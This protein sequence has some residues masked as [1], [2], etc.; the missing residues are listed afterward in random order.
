MVSQIFSNLNSPHFQQ[1]QSVLRAYMATFSFL[2]I[3]Q[4][5]EVIKTEKISIFGFLRFSV[6]ETCFPSLTGD[7]FVTLQSCGFD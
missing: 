7:L 4:L 3:R 5:T 6:K 2:G 1:K